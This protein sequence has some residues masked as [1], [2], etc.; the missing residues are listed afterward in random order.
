VT[1]LLLSTVPLLLLLLSYDS[2]LLLLLLLL[3][4][5]PLLVLLA[6]VQSTG[7]NNVTARCHASSCL[8]QHRY[9][10]SAQRI[11]ITLPF[12]PSISVLQ[13][14]PMGSSAAKWWKY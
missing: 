5:I 14:Q 10:T 6:T 7:A 4:L 11:V 13:P 8:S 2:L 12:T 9:E 3:L 1:A